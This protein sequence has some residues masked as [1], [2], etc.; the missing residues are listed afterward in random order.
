MKDN[1]PGFATTGPIKESV[2]IRT[3]SD[4][5]NEFKD[6]KLSLIAEKTGKHPVD[7][8]LDL[9]EVTNL[10]AEFFATLHNAGNLEYMKEII[11]DPVIT[12]GVS[13][14]GATPAFSLPDAISPK[15]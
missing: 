11:D 6:H 1:P 4:K 15:P 14:G 7:T 9:A 3:K 5:F 10:K 2:L 13:D 8:M 12:F